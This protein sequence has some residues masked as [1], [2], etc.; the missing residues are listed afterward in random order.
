[1]NKIINQPPIYQKATMKDFESYD[2]KSKEKSFL[3]DFKAGEN[4]LICGGVGVGKTHMALALAKC[5]KVEEESIY[6][7]FFF[8]ND[9]IET[10]NKHVYERCDKFVNEV[11][12]KLYYNK[13]TSTFYG[14]H[15]LI[16]DDFSVQSNSDASYKNLFN[17]INGRYNNNA[18]TIITCNLTLREFEKQYRAIFSRITEN[19]IA[20]ELTGKDLRKI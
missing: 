9:L 13:T 17:V 12:R 8:I 11:T 6:S 2:F 1:M 15:T 7:R 14:Y 16:I 20:I 10:Y 19:G 5:Q 4:I 18:S 3:S